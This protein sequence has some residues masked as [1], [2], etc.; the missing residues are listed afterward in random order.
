MLSSNCRVSPASRTADRAGRID[1]HDLADDEPIHEDADRGKVLLDRGLAE[2]GLEALDIG[3]DDDRPDLL[4]VGNAAFLAPAEEGDGVTVVGAAGVLIADVGGE[5]LGEADEHVV[6]G[7][8]DERRHV[9]LRDGRGRRRAEREESGR[10]RG[11][12]R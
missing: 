5:E 4:E 3:G 2:G 10:R 11:R 8:E 9:R 6:A 7:G 12:R 1:R